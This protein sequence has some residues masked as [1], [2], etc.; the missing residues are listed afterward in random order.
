MKVRIKFAKGGCM[1]YVGHLDIMR[2]FQKAVRRSGLPIKYSEGF[3]P[4]QIMSFAAPLG[5]GITSEG[6][7][8]DIELKEALPSQEGL[9]RL[10]ETMVEDMEILQFKYLPEGAKNA[11]SS[12]TAASYTLTYKKPEN[13]PFS[14]AELTH[15]KQLFFDDAASIPIVKKTKKGQREM[16]LKPL[17]YEFSIRHDENLGLAFDLMVSCGSVDNIKPELVMTTFMGSMGRAS[18]EQAFFIHRRDM[19]TTIDEHFVSLGEVGHDL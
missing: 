15:Q 1:K 2:Y 18:E 14:L 10:Q 12:V 19:F 17:I 3:N 13:F 5:V 16:D 8:M 11:M 9:E 4:H 7:Y 6:E